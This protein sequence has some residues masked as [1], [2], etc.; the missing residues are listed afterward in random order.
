M[1]EN[2]TETGEREYVVRLRIPQMPKTARAPR[3]TVESV[4]PFFW[5]PA[6]TRTHLNRMQKEGL[7]AIRSVLDAI[8]GRMDAQ[9]TSSGVK[10]PR[11]EVK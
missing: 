4:D 9:P 11:I 8:I 1:N 10:A 3:V 2:R 7:L 5:L 6:E